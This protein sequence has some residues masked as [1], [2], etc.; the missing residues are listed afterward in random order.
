[1]SARTRLFTSESVTEG[2][3]DK[4][5][6]QISDAILDAAL[7]DDPNSRVA[8]ET[9]LT[10][11]LVLV[12][13]EMTTK[14]Y[15]PIA[16]V[17][18][19]VIRDIGYDSSDKGFDYSTCSVLVA[20]DRQSP[21]IAQ[22]V[23]TGGAGDQGMMFGYACDETDELM[24]API[25]FAHSLTDRLSL[26]RRDNGI[27]PWLRPD[28]KSQVTVE[29]DGH[30]VKRIHTVVIAA[31]H[32]DNASYNDIYSGI[33]KYVIKPV[34][35][36]ELLDEKTI[37]HI[38]STGRF[39]LGGPSA[40]CGL[41][42]RKLINDTYGGTGRH[43][44]GAFCFVPGTLI[45]TK[46]GIR[47]IENVKVGDLVY[48]YNHKTNKTEFSE[49]SDSF[50]RE[51]LD[52]ET[53][54]ELVTSSGNTYE[55]TGEHPFYVK[56]PA[57][58]VKA[59]DLYPGAYIYFLDRTCSRMWAHVEIKSIEPSN[60]RCKVHNFKVSGNNNYFVGKDGLL[61]HNSGKDPSKVDRSGAYMARYIAKNVVAAELARRCEIQLA[62]A[63]GVAEPVSI[64][65]DAFG[66][67]LV[68]EEK[69][70]K[71]VREVFCC[72]PK[73]MIESLGLRR[74]IY[75][76]TASGGHFCRSEFPWERTDKAEEL[77]AALK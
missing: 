49:V 10:T 21:D 31:Q 71:A 60:K 26:V 29:Y 9:L 52:S 68:S 43:G 73:A 11:G 63:I 76:Q 46:R 15:I 27:L 35:P 65:I 7:K 75:R 24:P 38:N 30:L 77:K 32:D 66:S 17:A 67:N 13:G 51:L 25:Q 53:L 61:V 62:Y 48:S 64:H 56:G 58:Y 39:V 33:L 3:P 18:R 6:D 72:T 22:G 69:L 47:R 41:T 55:V 4:M 8:C 74:P 40:D 42:G 44:G 50:T 54:Y 57:K 34:L 19:G 70:E 16:E 20:L 5:A 1:M 45:H 2:H 23:D 12:A 59:E 37:I 28:G 14:T 36:E